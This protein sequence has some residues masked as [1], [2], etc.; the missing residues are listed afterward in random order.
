MNFIKNH[1][2]N[3]KNYCFK[4]D[5]TLFLI[6]H[7]V[8]FSLAPSL[9]NSLPMDSI[10]AIVWGQDL[11]W[12]TNKHPPLSGFL[13][14]IFYK[15]FFAN[16]ISIYIL[17]QACVVIGFIYIYKIA[18]LFF[19]EKKAL[20]STMLLQGVIYYNFTSIEYNVNVVSLALWPITAYYFYKSINENKLHQ[21]IIL[22]I[23]VGINVLNKYSAIYLFSGMI[24]YTIVSHETFKQ[25][26]NKKMY[27]A[28]I[29]AFLISFP[30]IYWL[31]KTDF[32]VFEYFKGRM[33]SGDQYGIFAHLIFPIRFLFAQILNGILTIVL[34]FTFYFFSKKD[35]NIEKNEKIENLKKYD[36]LYIF[37]LGIFPLFAIMGQSFISGN[38]LRTMWGTPFLYMLTIF[39]FAFFNFSINEKMYKKLKISIYSIM[40]I[41]AIITFGKTIRTKSVR[42]YFP[43]KQFVED[44]GEFWK[45]EVKEDNLKYVMGDI[46]YTSH[47]SLYHTNKPTIIY[48]IDKQYKNIL[49]EDEL[50]KNGIMIVGNTEHEVKKFQDYLSKYDDIKSY[51]FRT[52]NPLGKGKDYIL[53]YSIIIPNVSHETIVNN[54]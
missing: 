28:V 53:Y 43:K 17:S 37:C 5:L 18:K 24:A 20:I 35:K 11:S 23:S 22:G 38:K 25:L 42:S 15:L 52:K 4:N 48:D 31:Y 1:I 47:L 14:I 39:L 51:S 49:T 26:L 33:V 9:R 3:I 10:E 41:I 50:N 30:H 40:A 34:F 45:N 32:I 16:D 6:L 44:M 19:D 27:L 21:W 8:L 12:L 2:S 29:L 46:W 13:A 36:K 54:K 7:F